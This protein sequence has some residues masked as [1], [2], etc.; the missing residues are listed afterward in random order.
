MTPTLQNTMN[1]LSL[2][3]N[4]DAEH[5]ALE[6]AVSTWPAEIKDKLPTR[7]TCPDPAERER[8]FEAAR[9]LA[10]AVA[11]RIEAREVE[12]ARAKAMDER[13]QRLG[14]ARLQWDTAPEAQR[15]AWRAQGFNSARDLAGET[16]ANFADLKRAKLT[17]SDVSF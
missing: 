17:T 9:P 16:P 14:A 2:S 8:L 12:L 3:I 7:A 1:S 4:T 11:S 5:Q 6:E 13:N 15:Q 10:I